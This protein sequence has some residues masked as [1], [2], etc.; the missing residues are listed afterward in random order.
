MSAANPTRRWLRL[1]VKRA[2]GTR[3]G[4]QARQPSQYG[5]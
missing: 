1:G 4:M 2:T 5:R 3:S